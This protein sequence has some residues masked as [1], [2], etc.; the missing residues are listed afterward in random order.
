MATPTTVTPKH[1]SQDISTMENQIP[2]NVDIQD[3]NSTV[4]EDGPPTKTHYPLK[5]WLVFAGLCATG[6]ISALD[7]SIVSTSLP[8]II[9]DLE[10]GEN[11][12]WVVNVYFLTR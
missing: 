2:D 8:K 9:D 10:G 12:V 5:F 6:L 4:V 11:Y 3:K 7:G 1:A